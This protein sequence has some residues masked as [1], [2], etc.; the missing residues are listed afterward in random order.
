MAEN[1]KPVKTET[2]QDTITPPV[3]TPVVVSLTDACQ[4]LLADGSH[5]ALTAIFAKQEERNG[6]F[7]D[8]LANYALRYQQFI[9]SPVRD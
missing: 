1:I 6:S 7:S 4:Q 2:T 3:Q 8:T 5:P 9:N